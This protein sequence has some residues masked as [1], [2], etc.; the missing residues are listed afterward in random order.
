MSVRT[1]K[2]GVAAGLAVAGALAVASAGGP[3]SVLAGSHY[4]EQ[5]VGWHSVVVPAP[6]ATE[7]SVVGAGAVAPAD[8]GDLFLYPTAGDPDRGFVPGAAADVM[9][10]QPQGDDPDST[11]WD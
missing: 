8:D 10:P 9:D 3:G 1:R 2:L 11:E 6:G 7:G 5:G 4:A